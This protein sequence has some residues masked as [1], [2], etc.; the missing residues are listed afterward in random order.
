M[1]KKKNEKLQK[2]KKR[3]AE[4]KNSQSTKSMEEYYY[5]MLHEML[6]EDFKLHGDVTDEAETQSEVDFICECLV[7]DYAFIELWIQTLLQSPI[8]SDLIRLLSTPEYVSALFHIKRVDLSKRPYNRVDQFDGVIWSAPSTFLDVPAA[9]KSGV[10]SFEQVIVFHRGLLAHLQ[11]RFKQYQYTPPKKVVVRTKAQQMGFSCHRGY[12]FLLGITLLFELQSGIHLVLSEASGDFDERLEEF[13]SFFPDG[14][15]G[16][17]ISDNK[18]VR[19]LLRLLSDYD[20]LIS[21]L[22]EGYNFKNELKNLRAKQLVEDD[23]L[24]YME[25][26]HAQSSE[27]GKNESFPAFLRRYDEPLINGYW[28]LVLA[29]ITQDDFYIHVA[30][31]SHAQTDFIK[32]LLGINACYH[33]FGYF[34][35]PDIGEQPDLEEL[36]SLYDEAVFYL[37]DDSSWGTW[38]SIPKEEEHYPLEVIPPVNRTEII[39]ENLN[40]AQKY[41]PYRRL[42]KEL[43]ELFQGKYFFTRGGFPERK[44]LS[45]YRVMPGFKQ[46]SGFVREDMKE[47]EYGAE[48]LLSADYHDRI[49]ALS[50][51]WPIKGIPENSVLEYLSPEVFAQ[52]RDNHLHILTIES[53]NRELYEKN[54]II[55]SMV[56]DLSHYSKNFLNPRGLEK[57]GRELAKANGISPTLP[58]IQSDGMDIISHSGIE[59]FIHSQ[60][61]LIVNQA[62][63]SN[64][65]AYDSRDNEEENK[66]AIIRYFNGSIRETP[67]ENCI[68]ADVVA[69]DALKFIISQAAMQYASGKVESLRKRCNCNDKSSVNR[70]REIYREIS[71]S[72]EPMAVVRGFS[73]IFYPVKISELN[74]DWEDIY[75]VDEGSAYF[76]LM[77]IITEMVYN[78]LRH[79]APGEIRIDFT[80][81]SEKTGEVKVNDEIV[82]LFDSGL[83][84][85]VENKIDDSYREYTK[86]DETLRKKTQIFGKQ[87]DWLKTQGNNGMFVAEVYF[88]GDFALL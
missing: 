20:N 19:G 11:N 18:A 10:I 47:P 8:K 81:W 68:T 72:N 67:E 25:E 2:G 38:N 3:K 26:A 51:N 52:W 62:V 28:R 45:R 86:R 77:D 37:F 5:D 63:A 80:D 57:T 76:F 23:M 71:I 21:C 50:I 78:A 17:D 64:L 83:A 6:K 31:Y 79:G 13:V 49:N 65:S 48:W 12:D 14:F 1:T 82:D 33:L 58:E 35:N 42:R 22:S 54:R 9:V 46:D 74:E 70:I 16:T 69:A 87:R 61:S 44:A 66:Q 30:L 29:L 40:P 24:N 36:R 84:V 56:H 73:E 75:F 39:P 55:S 4:K 15:F 41:F 60:L 43:F 34:D 32:T 27:Y 53:K 7:E 85:R 88:P 59:S